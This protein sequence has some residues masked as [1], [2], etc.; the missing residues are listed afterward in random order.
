MSLRNVFVIKEEIDPLEDWERE[1]LDVFPLSLG[2]SYMGID[3]FDA[4]IQKHGF[5]EIPGQYFGAYYNP[6]HWSLKPRNE[7]DRKQPAVD[8]SHYENYVL[9]AK[10]AQAKNLR[11]ML[12]RL[13]KDSDE[14]T[15]TQYTPS[16]NRA[17]MGDTGI[18]TVSDERKIYTYLGLDYDTWERKQNAS[19]EDYVDPDLFRDNE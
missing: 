6:K 1:L 17:W 5:K 14:E 4:A 15:D 8:A 12:Q 18:S 19:R 16:I 9:V 13:P 11:K 3:A 7:W 2:D 10:T